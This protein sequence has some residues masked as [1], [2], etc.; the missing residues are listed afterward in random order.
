LHFFGQLSVD[1]MS[2]LF[3]FNNPDGRSI[4]A[5]KLSK[6]AF[7]VLSQTSDP[8]HTIPIP[9]VVLLNRNS[10]SFPLADL[11]KK[12]AQNHNFIHFYQNN[13]TEKTSFMSARLILDGKTNPGELT[14]DIVIIEN[15]ECLKGFLYQ[16]IFN[17][18]NIIEVTKIFS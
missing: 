6:A 15:E 13:S 7:G 8:Y 16:I 12:L 14:D 1:E 11:M 5:E 4:I 2:V 3:C 10:Q 9:K 18:A 17:P